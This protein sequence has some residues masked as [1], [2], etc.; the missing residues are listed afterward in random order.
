MAAAAVKRTEAVLFAVAV[1]SNKS[2]GEPCNEFHY[3]DVGNKGNP[4]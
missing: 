2:A 1:P 4:T 3:Y